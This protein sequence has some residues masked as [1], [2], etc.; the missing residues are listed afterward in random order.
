MK[1]QI[2]NLSIG[3][4]EIETTLATLYYLYNAQIDTEQNKRFLLMM[5]TSNLGDLNTG[6]TKGAIREHQ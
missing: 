1:D 6:P 2:I 3:S 5:P 4:T